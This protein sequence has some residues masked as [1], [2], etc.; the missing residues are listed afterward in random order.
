[1]HQVASSHDNVIINF[2][3]HEVTCRYLIP[4]VT[5]YLATSMSL[6]HSAI[7]FYFCFSIHLVYSFLDT[8]HLFSSFNHFW[9]SKYKNLRKGLIDTSLCLMQ[10]VLTMS[11]GFCFFSKALLITG[12]LS[13]DIAPMILRLF[14][15]VETNVIGSGFLVLFLFLRQSFQNHQF[16]HISLFLTRQS[17]ASIF[18][19][20]FS[21]T[22]LALR[23]P[24][25]LGLVS[26]S[27]LFVSGFYCL[28]ILDK[29]IELKDFNS[30]ADPIVT[31]TLVF[32]MYLFSLALWAVTFQTS[33][34][35]AM[36]S[37][38]KFL[39]AA[40]VQY[41][42]QFFIIPARNITS[43]L[44]FTVSTSTFFSEVLRDLFDSHKVYSF[45][46]ANF[47]D[48]NEPNPH[49]FWEDRTTLKQSLK[50]LEHDNEGLSSSPKQTKS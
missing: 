49:S 2:F 8:Y 31:K 28:D 39:T 7:L 4:A 45:Q 12:I 10:L 26:A 9:L 30:G 16:A 34:S 42:P 22:V 48:A 11:I 13:Q 33:L 17:S 41:I 1:M 50:K 47:D 18:A 14:H 5:L 25:V 3:K 23:F 46:I 37:L 44:I 21:L 20:C 24:M 38:P 6:F 29:L 43:N 40:V 19:F 15:F 32:C 27:Y 35:M 36:M